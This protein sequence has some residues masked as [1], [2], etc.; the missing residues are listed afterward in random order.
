M[1]I[2]IVDDVSG[3]AQQTIRTEQALRGLEVQFGMDDGPPAPGGD[4]GGSDTNSLGGGSFSPSYTP[5][6]NGLW[7]QVVNVS[8]GLAYVNLNNATDAVYEILS[9]TDLTLTNWNIEQE[10]WPTNPAVMPFIVPEGGRTNLFIW[11][12]D[13]TGVAE[14]GNET[15]DWWFW[16]YF[17]TTALSDTNLDGQGNTLLYDF[18]HGIDPNIIAFSLAPTNQYVTG[19][20][21]IVPIIVTGGVP[22]SM[23]VLVNDTNFDSAQWQ[24]YNASPVVYLGTND[25]DYDVWV[26]LRGRPTDSDQTWHGT[27]LTR[28]TIPPVLTITNPVATS[29][30]RPTIQLQGYSDEPLCSLSYDLTNFMLTPSSSTAW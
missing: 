23:A 25:G 16:E 6:T 27:T 29:T 2:Y 1:G 30:A 8:N 9:K 22:A 26:G 28:D 10:V 24:P 11:A 13:W 19:S 21:S 12:R 5:L 18:Q 4:S 14:N 7:L 3:A 17:G 20:S 15:P